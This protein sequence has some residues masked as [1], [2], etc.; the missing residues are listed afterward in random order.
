MVTTLKDDSKLRKS[1]V[2][3]DAQAVLAWFEMPKDK[4]PVPASTINPML[5][6]LGTIGKALFFINAP[7][8][9]QLR[10]ELTRFDHDGNFIGNWYLLNIAGDLAVSGYKIDFLKESGGKTP[11]FS[12][13]KNGKTLYVEANAKQPKVPVDNP[14]KIQQM[15]RDIIEEKRQK[16]EDPQY[17]PGVI[18]ADISPAS[19]LVNENGLPNRFELRGDL[20]VPDKTSIYPDA[21]EY[22]VYKDQ[23]FFDRPHNQGNFFHYLAQ[24]FSQIDLAKTQVVQCI[25]SIYRHANSQ[26]GRTEFVKGNQLII[27]KNFENLALKEIAPHRYIV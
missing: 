11:D 23:D 8:Q 15:V 10:S 24:E 27:R 14:T 26:E 1:R 19:Y 5:Y 2:Y 12:A 16:F 3:E 20:C 13:T 9:G 7:I 4:R 6:K 25:L 22:P 18:V 17:W 21:F